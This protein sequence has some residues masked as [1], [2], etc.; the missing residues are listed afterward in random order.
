MVEQRQL[1]EEE[2][3]ENRRIVQLGILKDSGTKDLYIASA[4]L[5]GRYGKEGEASTIINYL[6]AMSNP[7]ENIGK[8]LSKSYALLAK[9]ALESDESPY[10]SGGL[11]PRQLLK[12]NKAIYEG[13]IHSVKVADILELMGISEVHE[14][15]ISPEEKNMYLEELENKNKELYRQLISTYFDSLEK[16]G[17]GESL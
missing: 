11:S 6:R 8:I 10:D 9:Q 3:K 15:R 12:S 2:K 7:S 14:T 5:T 1:T 4:G 13:A 16:T 17:I